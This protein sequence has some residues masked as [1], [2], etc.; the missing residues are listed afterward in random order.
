MDQELRRKIGNQNHQDELTDRQKQLNP[1]RG[2]DFIWQ[3]LRPY[4][5]VIPN[6]KVAFIFPI[7]CILA[8]IFPNLKKYFPKCEGKGSFF[9]FQIKSLRG[10]EIPCRS[11]PTW[12]HFIQ[13]K[14]EIFIYLSWDKLK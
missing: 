11:C 4:M 3:F 14:Q 6:P 13:D 10:V 2:S 9:K 12:P 8:L 5:G 7:S 1:T